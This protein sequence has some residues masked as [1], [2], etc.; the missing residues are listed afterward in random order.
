MDKLTPE[1][2]TKNMKAVKSSGTQIEKLLAKVLWKNGL[3]Y[4]KNDKTVFG[5]PDFTFKGLKIAVFCDSEFWHG[6]DWE[7]RKYDFKSNQAFW[8]A[9]IERNIQRD[10]VVNERLKEDG[11]TVL[12]FWGKDI[13]K[14]T[15][16]CML[17]IKNE[18]VKRQNEKQSSRRKT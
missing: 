11:W 12:R 14:D 7:Q 18:V 10:K 13:E 17:K 8:I 5:K 2:R 4:R 1:Q 9:K 15:Y 6:K 16:S 3:R